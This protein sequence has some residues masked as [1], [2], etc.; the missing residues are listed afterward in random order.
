MPRK[1]GPAPAYRLH[2]PSGQ[3]RVIVGG[4]HIYL[5]RYGATESREKYARVI[6]ESSTGQLR[7]MKPTIDVCA[8]ND[9]LGWAVPWKTGL[10]LEALRT[11]AMQVSIEAVAQS[12]NNWRLT[13]RAVPALSSTTRSVVL[14]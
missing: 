3:V 11:L 2:K 9:H 4:D 5:G 12:A 14:T 13:G 1:P 8:A 7:G 10:P 6:A